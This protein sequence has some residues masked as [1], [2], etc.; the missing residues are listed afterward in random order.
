MVLS[1][2]LYFGIHTESFTSFHGPIQ[3]KIY[4]IQKTEDTE[5]LIRFHAQVS[6]RNK[7]ECATNQE[8][9]DAAA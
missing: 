8:V 6:H 7:Y 5:S 4:L 3:T 1:A 2:F 9:L